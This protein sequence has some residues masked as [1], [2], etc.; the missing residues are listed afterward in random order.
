[1]QCLHTHCTW[2]GCRCGCTIISLQFNDRRNPS[3][4][5]AVFLISFTEVF[6]YIPISQFRQFVSLLLLPPKPVHALLYRFRD[7]AHPPARFVIFAQLAQLCIFIVLIFRILLII[8]TC[9]IAQTVS[10]IIQHLLKHLFGLSGCQSRVFNFPHIFP[11]LLHCCRCIFNSLTC[12]TGFSL[13]II[14]D[15]FLFLFILQ[16]ALSRRCSAATFF[17]DR[18]LCNAPSAQT[19]SASNPLMP[20]FAWW[21]WSVEHFFNLPPLPT[22][23]G[24]KFFFRTMTIIVCVDFVVGRDVGCCN[25]WMI[26]RQTASFMSRLVRL[27]NLNKAKSEFWLSI[28][29]HL[30][31][32]PYNTTWLLASVSHNIPGIFWD[33]HHQT[34]FPSKNFLF[35]SDNY[36][37]LAVVHLYLPL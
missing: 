16:K 33:K 24:E 23:N 25:I 7:H 14:L 13:N 11:L 6:G 2:W 4:S 15:P 21:R 31:C 17:L 1:M 22:G 27:I 12:R 10:H 19:H 26:W 37:I 8:R 9:K 5:C 34:S 30:I 36:E 28:K 35:L 32:W 18:K 3:F 20:S 29:W